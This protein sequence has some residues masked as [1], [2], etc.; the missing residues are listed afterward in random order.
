MSNYNTIDLSRRGLGY[1]GAARTREHPTQKTPQRSK[2]AGSH[3]QLSQDEFVR[4]YPIGKLIFWDRNGDGRFRWIHGDFVTHVTGTRVRAGNKLIRKTLQPHGIK[5][6]YQL[7]NLSDFQNSAPLP[8]KEKIVPTPGQAQ[9]DLKDAQTEAIETQMLNVEIAM[10]M[11][12]YG[13]FSRE[14][15]KLKAMLQPMGITLPESLIQKMETTTRMNYHFR[16]T[17]TMLDQGHLEW[18]ADELKRALK[19]AEKLGLVLDT[20]E[21]SIAIRSVPPYEISEDQIKDLFRYLETGP[22]QK[23]E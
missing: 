12:D 18:A 3:P 7:R 21:I 22:D 11:G 9:K 5:W 14:L 6:A 16:E 20:K 10:E 4:G 19:F 13:S 1:G 23:M 2:P 15:D 8:P 17:A